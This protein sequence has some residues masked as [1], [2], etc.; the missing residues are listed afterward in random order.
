MGTVHQK[1]GGYLSVAARL[2]KKAQLLDLDGYHDR[3]KE[4]REEAA[5]HRALA[6]RLRERIG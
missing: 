2:E 1:I 6:K 4:C 3:A 5:E